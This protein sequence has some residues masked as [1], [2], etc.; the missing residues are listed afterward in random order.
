MWSVEAILRR[1]ELAGHDPVVLL[2]DAVRSRS[3][4]DAA[5]PARALHSRLVTALDGHVTPSVASFAEL[6]PADCPETWRP[7]LERHAAAV[8]ERRA[9]LGTEVAIERPQWAIEALGDV[10]TDPVGRLEWEDNA[11][12]AATYRELVGQTDPVDALGDAPPSGLP[13]KNAMWRAAHAALDLPQAGPAQRE[14][15]DGLLRAQVVAQAREES[16]APAYVADELAAVSQAED[17]A[18]ETATVCAT[19]A[20]TEP[21][22]ERAA[23]LRS[24]AAAATESLA[25]L[26]KQRTWSGRIWLGRCGRRATQ[27]R[28]TRRRPRGMS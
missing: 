17:R 11:G 5:A 24:E 9:V 12:L 2:G 8:D 3:L 21:D 1:A 18:R 15:S 19:Q 26:T 23:V 25:T 6:I 4:D 16:W 14:A 28:R 10:P 27:S 20:D 22:V 7:W 13:E